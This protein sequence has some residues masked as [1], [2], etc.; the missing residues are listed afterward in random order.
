[1]SYELTDDVHIPMV[2]K[3]AIEKPILCSRSGAVIMDSRHARHG[4]EEAPDLARAL[5]VIIFG[6]FKTCVFILIFILKLNS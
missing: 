4:K 1:M 3:V 5:F 2:S 6:N